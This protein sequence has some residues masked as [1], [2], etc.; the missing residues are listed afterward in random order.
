MSGLRRLL[1]REARLM[2]VALQFFTRVPVTLRT[3]DPQWLNACARYFPLVGALV[4]AAGAAALLAASLA[5]PAPVAVVASMAFTA[6]LTGGFHED[7]LADTCDGLGG[8]VARERALEIMKDSRVGSYGVLG[9]VLTLG[10]KAAALLALCRHD[11]RQAALMLVLAHVV[12]RAMPL[13]VLRVLPYAGDVAHA[14]AKPLARQVG[15]ASLLV[16]LAIA[17]GFAALGLAAGLPARG[18]AAA[19]GAALLVTAACARWFRRRLG[20]FTGDTLGALQQWSELAALLAA[21]AGL[22]A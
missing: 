11:L 9:L 2:A 7:G 1:A 5:W 13:I 22:Q 19:I 21:G 17:A 20:G 3:F 14:K 12:S 6:W 18:V 4:G 16:A 8:A 15:T 10:A